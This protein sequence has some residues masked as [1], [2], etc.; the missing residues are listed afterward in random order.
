[1]DYLKTSLN[2]KEGGIIALY[3]GINPALLGMIPY[4]GLAFYCFELCKYECVKRFP[5][6]TC[7]ESHDGTRVLKVHF[8]LICG[9]MS[10]AVAQTFS[11]PLDVARR[12]MQLAML[13]PETKIFA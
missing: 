4:A 9:G 3:R 8:K 13:R 12:R 5:E 6:L 10:G 11:Y 7:Y 1:M 2:I